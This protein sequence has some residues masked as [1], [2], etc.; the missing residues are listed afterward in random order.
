MQLSQ[1]SDYATVTELPHLVKELTLIVIIAEFL[2][3]FSFYMS[4][5]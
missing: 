2:K 1:N 3:W 4:T 5:D